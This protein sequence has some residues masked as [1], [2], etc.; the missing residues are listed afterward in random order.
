M[1]ERDG[2]F[3]ANGFDDDTDWLMSQLGSGRRPDLE[4]RQ[5]PQPP[6][7]PEAEA[8]RVEPASPSRPRRR[9]EESLDW[10]SVAEPAASDDAPTRALPVVGEPIEPTVSGRV[11]APPAWDQPTSNPPAWNPPA[12]NQPAWTNPPAERPRIPEPPVDDRLTSVEPPVGGIVPPAFARQPEPPHA[13]P[14]PVTPPANF[15]LTWGESPEPQS[16]DT[17]AGLRAA[18]RQLA[19]P[20]NTPPR[21]RETEARPE[22]GPEQPEAGSPF[23]GFTPPPVAR[24]SF[25]PVTPAPGSPDDF[26]DELWSALHEDEQPTETEPAADGY[27]HASYDDRPAF[28]EPVERGAY[29]DRGAYAEQRAYAE[30]SA[31]DRAAAYDRAGYDGAGYAQPGYDQGAYDPTGYEQPGSDQGWADGAGHADPVGPAVGAG[32]GDFGLDGYVQDFAARGGSYD[33]DGDAR[34]YGDGLDAQG[35]DWE[36]YDQDGYDRDGYDRQGYTRPAY[37][38]AGHR[39]NGADDG[40]GD[41]DDE[42]RPGPFDGAA[43]PTEGY[44]NDAYGNDADGFGPDAYADTGDYGADRFGAH[45]EVAA[46]DD[47]YDLREL[48]RES[49]EAEQANGAWSDEPTDWREDVGQ[50]AADAADDV[51]WYADDL[52]DRRRAPEAAQPS[53][54][55]RSEADPWNA[56]ESPRARE[57]AQSGYLWNLTPDPEGRDP[58]VPVE[59]SGDDETPGPRR[60]AA[61]PAVPG[62]VDDDPFGL[63]APDDRVDDRQAYDDR[64]AFDDQPALDDGPAHD[65]RPAFDDPWAAYDVDERTTERPERGRPESNG[66][67]DDGLAALFGGAGFGATGP[68]SVVDASEQAALDRSPARE[69]GYGYESPAADPFGRDDRGGWDDGYGAARATPPRPGDDDR[70]GYRATPAART[71]DDA[72]GRSPVKVLTWVAGGLALVVLIVAVVAFG[73]RFLAPSDAGTAAPVATEEP[74]AAPTAPQPAGVHSWEALFGTEC[75]E[76]FESPWAEEFTVVDCAS[77]HTAQLAYRGTFAGDE[78]AEFPGEEA[79]AAQSQ[80]LCAA[81][82][83][84]DPAAA[85]GVGELQMVTAFP[86]TAEQWDAGQRSYY[87]F[88]EQV[89]GEPLTVSLA[90]AGPAAA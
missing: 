29:D 79:L 7:A 10:F 24:R 48:W 47:G 25:T 20:S 16:L 33:G 23:E 34:G 52:A 69:S 66:A 54:D 86:V 73:T 62:T 26:A 40:R 63:G 74:V 38:A 43:F 64:R 67:G 50:P 78:A 42:T 81:E 68:M 82:G 11:D 87:C 59:E 30:Q 61:T 57:F 58:K 84:I 76:P 13:P 85:G 12:W 83:V 46:H 2:R 6:V 1:N 37:D 89:S 3:G 44:G 51:R 22:P 39:A 60:G 36:G 19:D 18:F 5:A 17:E 28:D 80:E 90:G 55:E 41:G 4:G 53:A 72:T 15:A 65:D 27:D 35:Y 56:D 8:P 71:D 45:D 21:V 70:G 31:Y 75:L 32:Q 49:D 14:G 88:V 9:S 77:P